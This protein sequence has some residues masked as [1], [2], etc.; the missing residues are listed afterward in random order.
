[1][2]TNRFVHETPRGA[3]HSREDGQAALEGAWRTDAEERAHP[4]PKIE[5]A[6]MDEQS[7]EHVLVSAHMRPP[8]PTGLVEMR[9]R[10]LE[11]LPASAKEAFPAFGPDAT[12]IRIYRISFGFLVGPRLR[13]AIRLADV[14]A[15]LQRLQIVHRGAAVVALVGDDFLDPPTASSVTA[16]TAS[17]C[18]AASG[19]V[20]WMV[21]VSPSSAPCTVTPTIAPV[22]RSTACSALCAKCV[23]PSFIFVILASRSYGCVQSSFEPL[24]LR[25]RSIRAKSVRV[26]VPSNITFL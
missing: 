13:P 14:G 16:A 22:S 26:G 20:S 12:S 18:S 21:V 25:F 10:A 2:T 5:R 15:N 17:S 8:Q 24:F 11:Q 9:T 4:E 1:M 23:R 3:E 6:G 19:S 7:L